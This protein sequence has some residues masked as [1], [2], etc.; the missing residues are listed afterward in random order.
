MNNIE[1]PR[2][3]PPFVVV[4]AGGPSSGK[5]SALASLRDRLT[6]RG[7]QVLTVP[8]NATHF[9]ANSDGFQREWAG[10]HAQVKMQRIFLD[11]QIAQEEAFKDFAA[12]HPTKPA[13]LLLDCCS[14]SSKVYC[15]DEQWEEV[16]SYPGKTQYTE[17]ELLRRYDLVIHMTTCAGTPFYE[18]GAGSNNPGRYHNH[19]EAKQTDQRGLKIF[20]SH[21]QFRVVRHTETFEDKL[22]QVVDFVNDALHIEG[23]VGKRD[24]RPLQPF[25][26][27]PLLNKIFEENCPTAMVTTTTFLDE[28]MQHSVRRRSTVPI[29]LF[30]NRLDLVDGEGPDDTKEWADLL[31]ESTYVIYERRH[32]V[33][34]EG[35]ASGYMTRKIINM[36]EYHAA[37]ESAACQAATTKY[38][39]SFLKGSHYYELF[40]FRPSCGTLYL[41]LPQ[42]A[43]VP[44]GLSELVTTPEALADTMSLS[45]PGLSF[46]VHSSQALAAAQQVSVE[47]DRAVANSPTL[48]E[49]ARTRRLRRHSTEEAA[50]CFGT[51]PERSQKRRCQ[52]LPAEMTTMSP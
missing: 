3:A 46:V 48:V 32:H 21:P 44:E 11:Y 29:D 20:A 1:N 4:L 33:Q 5:S 41:D 39:L 16:L 37:R 12:L 35:T 34:P 36:E 7:F 38:V 14:V 25:R 40:F 13:V 9:L 2:S 22:L 50:A 18:W 28:N 15:S 10:Q 26:S 45:P 23:L 42:G 52:E 43:A 51:T 8:E 24:R 47:K 49:K 31:K 30:I 6:A 19:E 27:N 17:K